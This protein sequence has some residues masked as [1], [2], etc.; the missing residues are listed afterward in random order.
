MQVTGVDG[1]IAFENV[2]VLGATAQ[3][4]QCRI[5]RRSVWLPRI[6]VSGNLE[7]S[8]QSCRLLVRRWV[9]QDRRLLG[10]DV[11][12]PPVPTPAVARRRASLHLIPPRQG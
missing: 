3:A 5:R 8:R 2:R 12:S 4:V 11:Q 10:I 1:F 6:H 7:V 9:A